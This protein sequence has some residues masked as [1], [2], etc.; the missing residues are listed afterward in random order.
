M[1]SDDET[2]LRELPGVPAE[3]ADALGAAWITTA[4]QLVAAAAALGDPAAMAEH[5]GLGADEFRRAVGAAEAAIAPDELAR[6]KAP[7][8]SREY[9]RGALP[10]DPP[11]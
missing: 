7:V 2:P 11:G 4:E 3:I 6:L 9:G 10:P 8:D 5:L 1:R